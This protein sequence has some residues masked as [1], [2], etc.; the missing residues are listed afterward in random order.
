MFNYVE[1]TGTDYG[2]L[3]YE[4]FRGLL[5]QL[6]LHKNKSRSIGAKG[7]NISL[8]DADEQLE[9]IYDLFIQEEVIKDEGQ[10]GGG[11]LSNFFGG[12]SNQKQDQ[13]EKDKKTRRSATFALNFNA[14][15]TQQRS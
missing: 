7:T 8:S 3:T 2:N 1:T 5:E 14:K 4:E 11:F 6:S 10:S 13:A 12:G 15:Q 9:K